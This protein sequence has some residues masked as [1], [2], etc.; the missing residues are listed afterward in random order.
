MSKKDP[1]VWLPLKR[2]DLA[3]L[4]EQVSMLIIRLKKELPESRFPELL[5]FEKQL[6]EISQ[7]NMK[8]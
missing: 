6:F 4:L 1:T 8:A 5:E 2:K 3:P 7:K